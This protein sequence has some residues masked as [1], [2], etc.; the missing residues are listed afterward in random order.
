MRFEGK[1]SYFKDLAQRVKCY[2]NI[3]KTLARRHQHM[4]SY[5]FGTAS[6]STTPFGKNISIGVGK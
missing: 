4:R 3:P 6:L 1:H 5:T 2:K